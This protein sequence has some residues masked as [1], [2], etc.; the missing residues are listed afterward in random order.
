[1]NIEQIRS[2]FPALERTQD[3]RPVIYLD[4][5]AGTQVP[6]AVI[7][8]ISHALAAGISNHGE[9]SA[10]SRFTDSIVDGARAAMADLYNASPREIAFGQN[11]T[12][13]TLALSRALAA[14]WEA[15][16]E[17]VL[18]RMDHDANV[19]PWLRAAEERGVVVRWVEFEDYVFAPDAFD[20]VLG[21]RTRL[22]AVTAASNALGTVT[23]IPAISR[24]VRRTDALL[25]VDAV[26]AAPHRLIDVNAWDVDF[27]VSSAYKFYGPHIGILYGKA[28][29]L[30]SLPAY[31]VRPAPEHGPGRWENGTQSFEALAGVTTAVDYLAA[32]G[33]GDTRRRRLE[34]AYAAIAAHEA[35]LGDRFLAGIA[36]FDHVRLFGV[37]QG[38]R[39]STFS[40]AV[41]GLTPESVASQLADRGIFVTHGTYYAVEVMNSLEQDEL[42]RV[43]FVHYNTLEEVD[44]VLNALDD[45]G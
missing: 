24:R 13:H 34:T 20:E 28:K 10:S 19:A 1:M 42:V 16:D 18:T 14:T 3:G 32:L 41:E 27:L 30:E 5:P 31:K 36:E 22:V 7:D 40:I 9:P 17:I 12:S 39:T 15:G 35:R 25:F 11:M 4:G 8:A 43:G 38:D 6:V 2:Q 45:L 29:H 44:A 33:D 23:D 21:H 37:E 26:H